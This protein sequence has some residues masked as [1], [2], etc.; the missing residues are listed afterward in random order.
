[1]T[2]KEQMLNDAK[3][4][5]L[6]T[7]EFAETVVYK[8]DYDYDYLTDTDGNNIVDVDGYPIL[9]NIVDPKEK[10]I[11]AFVIREQI[12]PTSQNNSRTLNQK[13][14]I[15]F[16]NDSVYGVTEISKGRDRVLIPAMLGE[17]AEEFVVSEIIDKD[18]AFF[19]VSLTR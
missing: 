3:D 16:M 17:E 8:T 19:R 4:V 6:N 5:I 10:S 1:M 18:E 15:Y 7:D 13:I 9:V 12:E 2:F 14:E 11:K